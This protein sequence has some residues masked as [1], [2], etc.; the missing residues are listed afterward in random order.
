MEGED[1]N[2]LNARDFVVDGDGG[3]LPQGTSVKWKD[4]S[5]DLSTPG[6]RKA[7]LLVTKGSETKEIEYNYTV[8]PKIK[9]RTENG[10][11][12][13]FFAFKGTKEGNLS[14]VDGGW[15]NPYGRN[16]EGYTC[17]LYTSPSP[18]DS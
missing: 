9:A 11:T 7:T 5:L 15:A 16:I 6:Q 14:K 4:S 2:Q 17:L 3:A 18:R 8:H 12:G 1:K 10:V 13:K